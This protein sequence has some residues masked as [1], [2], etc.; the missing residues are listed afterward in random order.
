LTAKIANRGQKAVEQLASFQL[1]KK[2]LIFDKN[3][4]K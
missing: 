4:Q 3:N 2:V 1:Q